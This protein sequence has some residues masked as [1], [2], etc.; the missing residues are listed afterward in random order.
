MARMSQVV[1]GTVSDVGDREV[2]IL[3]RLG[4]ATLRFGG[5]FDITEAYRILQWGVEAVA[6]VHL[7]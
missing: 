4:R 7:S 6:E 1:D 5:C 2:R 3:I